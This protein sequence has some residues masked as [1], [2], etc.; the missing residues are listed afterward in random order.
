M[1]C[2]FAAGPPIVPA[3]WK[4]PCEFLEQAVARDP[5]FAP[6]WRFLFQT[7]NL[8]G[9][10]RRRRGEESKTYP[11][12]GE[13]LARRVIALAPG[14]PDGYAMLANLARGEGKMLEAM[15]L[16][17]QALAR[18]PDDTEVMNGYANDLWELGYLKEALAV[19]ERQHLLE[20]LIPVYNQF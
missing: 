1:S 17:K 10:N 9:V 8:D 12:S 11:E 19:R 13:T 2:S 15:D 20:P 4:K 18:D 6:S 5:N 7:R 3:E 14:S 16:R